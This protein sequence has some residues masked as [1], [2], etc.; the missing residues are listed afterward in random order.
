MVL[1]LH[2][3]DIFVESSLESRRFA[4]NRSNSLRIYLPIIQNKNHFDLK[5]SHFFYQEKLTSGNLLNIVANI[6]SVCGICLLVEC[7]MGYVNLCSIR[8]ILFTFVRQKIAIVKRVFLIFSI[9]LESQSWNTF[10]VLFVHWR[11]WHVLHRYNLWRPSHIL[12]S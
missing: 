12:I 7:K 10:F 1:F 9:P 6:S 5:L 11:G 4:G 8:L 3:F 2:N